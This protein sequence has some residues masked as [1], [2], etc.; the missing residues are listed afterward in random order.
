MRE[1]RLATAAMPRT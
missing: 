1:N